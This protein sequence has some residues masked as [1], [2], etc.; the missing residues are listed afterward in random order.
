MWFFQLYC[1][2]INDIWAAACIKKL[3]LSQHFSTLFAAQVKQTHH[4][5]HTHGNHCYAF[6][7]P[8]QRHLWNCA[9]VRKTTG[10]GD[11]INTFVCLHRARFYL[12]S[13]QELGVTAGRRRRRRNFTGITTNPALQTIRTGLN[14]TPSLTTKHYWDLKCQFP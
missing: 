1:V 5:L 8:W 7:G 2:Y 12:L 4:S 3:N 14:E 6:E 9:N 11:F 13:L 10:T